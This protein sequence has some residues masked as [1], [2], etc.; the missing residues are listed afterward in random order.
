MNKYIYG[1]LGLS[2][3]SLIFLGYIFTRDTDEVTTAENQPV[4]LSIDYTNGTHYGYINSYKSESGRV[5]LSIDFVQAF[6][7]K[8]SS[9]MASVNE[10]M[11]PLEKLQENVRTNYPDET[12]V[13]A[14]QNNTDASVYFGKMSEEQ[15]IDFAKRT[16]CF[17]YGINYTRNKS[18]VER[19][20]SLEANFT[21][22]IDGQTITESTIIGFLNQ[23]KARNPMG[24]LYK[25]TLKNSIVTK[26][27][28]DPQ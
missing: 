10:G 25:I 19:E 1:I 16:G 17:P 2:I 26:I 5:Y 24:T 4:D 15:I 12:E 18:T 13:L 21:S 9:F 3:A 22:T 8:K 14:L 11:C 7:S 23:K 28:I 6:A 27:G 20:R